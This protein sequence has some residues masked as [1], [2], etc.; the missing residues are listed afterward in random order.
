[1]FSRALHVQF[2][3]KGKNRSIL[4]RVRSAAFSILKDRIRFFVFLLVIDSIV[5]FYIFS[6][7]I[8]PVLNG[9]G[10]ATFSSEG[11]KKVRIKK[12]LYNELIKPS[13]GSLNR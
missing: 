2:F 9:S 10:G 13:A 3:S 8:V 6:Q 1:M 4:H 7:Y 12:D 11:I 5:A